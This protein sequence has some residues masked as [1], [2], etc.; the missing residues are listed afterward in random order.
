ML[1][2]AIPP[3]I[4]RLLAEKPLNDACHVLAEIRADRHYASVDARLDL[5]REQ[6][7]AVPWASGVPRRVVADGADC[8]PR[9]LARS[10]DAQVAEHQ[11]GKQRDPLRVRRAVVPQ[12]V[13]PPE[14]QKA[15]APAFGGNAGTLRGDLVGRRSGQVAHRLPAN[16]RVRIEQPVERVHWAGPPSLIR[17]P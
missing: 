15:R 8:V 16:R 3:A 14:S 2:L 13:L 11:Q 12:P 10:V 7:S 9:L 17:A 1:L 6:R 5:A 4:R